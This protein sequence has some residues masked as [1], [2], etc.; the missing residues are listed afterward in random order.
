[1]WHGFLC[2]LLDGID[3]CVFVAGFGIDF[4]V[5]SFYRFGMESFAFCW[6]SLISVFFFYWIWHGFLCL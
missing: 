1:M 4:C 5:F 2:F 6:M 3:L